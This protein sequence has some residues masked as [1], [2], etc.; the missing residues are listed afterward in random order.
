MRTY[1]CIHCGNTSS[2]HR[3]KTNKFCSVKCQQSYARVGK[4]QSW[5]N[6][7]INWGAQCIPNWIKDTN[8]YLAQ[9]KGYACECCGISK[10]N[11]KRLVLECDHIDGVRTNNVP[12]NL[13]IS[14]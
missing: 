12:S 3:S 2:W 10:Y 1:N 6:E 11:G 7:E 9:T 13:L 5:L 4:I 14:V 8:G